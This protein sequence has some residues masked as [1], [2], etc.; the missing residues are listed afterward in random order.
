MKIDFSLIGDGTNIQV[1]LVEMLGETERVKDR[2]YTQ[3]HQFQICARPSKP[4]YMSCEKFFAYM[5]E[6]AAP[7]V[8]GGEYGHLHPYWAEREAARKKRLQNLE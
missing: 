4:E 7:P 2:F 1:S 5:E 8:I 6:T 3:Q